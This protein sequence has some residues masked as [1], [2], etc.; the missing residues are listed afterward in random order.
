M[1]EQV[2]ETCR[3]HKE[4]SEIEATISG[5]VAEA[6]PTRAVEPTE[7]SQFQAGIL[8]GVRLCQTLRIDLVNRIKVRNDEQM[9]L[10]ERLARQGI[11]IKIK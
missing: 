7:W 11:V 8:S 1:T 9:I 2:L 6:M 5:L 10:L 4:L 3:I